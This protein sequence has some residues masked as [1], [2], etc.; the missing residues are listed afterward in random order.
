MGNSKVID[1]QHGGGGRASHQLI[2]TIFLKHFDNPWLRKSDDQAVFTSYPGR[3]VISTDSHVVSPLFFP[4]GNIGSLAIHGTVNDISMAGAQPLY[5]TAA[6]ILEE[7][8]SLDTLEAIVMSMALAAKEVGVPIVAGDTKVVE[9]GR[10]DGVYITTTGVGAVLS[11]QIQISAD[12]ARP[13]NKVLI[14]GTIADHGMAIMACRENLKFD[15]EIT[16]DTTSLHDLVAQM[17]TAEPTGIRCLRDPTRGGVGAALNEISQLSRVGFR[18]SEASLPIRPQVSAACEILGID[19]LFVAN[20]GKLICICEDNVAERLLAIMKSHHHGRNAAIIGTVSDDS[21]SMVVL[22][23]CLGG[24][25][26]VD[27]PLGE[28]LPRIC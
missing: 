10:G 23:T 24:S 8:F 7:G 20:E 28:Q 18:I 2:Q 27:W 21:E 1:L 11:D 4:G 19:P 16:S 3:M 12:R 15:S 26:V 9:R 22:N 13:G 17:V 6:F 25:R 5:I 14:N